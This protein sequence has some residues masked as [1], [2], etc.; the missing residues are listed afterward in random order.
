MQTIKFAEVEHYKNK[1]VISLCPLGPG[2]FDINNICLLTNDNI[3]I[4]KKGKEHSFDLKDIL[5]IEI[6]HKVLLLPAVSGGILMPLFL[7]GTFNNMGDLWVM[8]SLAFG[9]LM[10]LYYGLAGSDTLSITTKVKEY[11]IFILHPQ[12]ELR[13]F[14]DF[15]NTVGLSPFGPENYFCIVMDDYQWAVTQ[16]AGKF[17]VLPEGKTLYGRNNLPQMTNRLAFLID[18][19]FAKG[20]RIDYVCNKDGQ[21]L[22][23]LFS[24]VPIGFLKPL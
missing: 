18:S 24:D 6:K 15:V 9:G 17:A 23:T 16:S 22:P 21:L 8:M 12:K 13:R 14:V 19:P 4:V 5:Q 3:I 7:V 10:L 20:M 2:P 1:P 11:D